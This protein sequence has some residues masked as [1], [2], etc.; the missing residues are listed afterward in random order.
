MV[1]KIYHYD[2]SVRYIFLTFYISNPIQSVC[3]GTLYAH[4]YHP[5]TYVVEH[6]G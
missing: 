2:S 4:L 1:K 6:F 5:V 3:H